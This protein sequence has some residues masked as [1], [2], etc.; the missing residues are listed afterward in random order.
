MK[1]RKQKSI[2]HYRSLNRNRKGIK[3]KF[4]AGILL[5]VFCGSLLC[6]LEFQAVENSKQEMGD[7]NVGHKREDADI[8][9]QARDFGHWDITEKDLVLEYDDRYSL[10]DI[11]EGWEVLS[12]KTGKI[13]S[14]KVVKGENTGITDRDVI[15]QSNGSNGKNIIASGV[16]TAEV[17]LVS[18]EQLEIA[19][20]ILDG[21]QCE[22]IRETIEVIQINV[23]VEPADLTLIYIAG[24]SN[25]EGWCSSSTGYRVEESVVCSEGEVYSTYAPLSVRANQISGVSFSKLCTVNNAADFVAGNLKSDVSVSGKRLEYSLNKLTAEGRGKTGPDSGL[26]YEWNRLT[27]DK[28]WIVNTAQ[29]GTSISKWIPGE[30]CYEQSMAV[31]W[32]VQKTYQA[33][34]EAGHYKAG[35][36]LLF[37]LQGESDKG[38]TAESYYKLFKRVCNVMQEELALDRIG[39][40]MVRSNEGSYTNEEDISMSGPRIAQ[41]VAGNSRE[42]PEV[43]VVS[44]VNEQ[45]VSDSGVRNYFMSTYPQGEL[46]YPTHNGTLAIPISMS[47]IHAD[48]HYSQI[49][50]NENG[51]TAASGMYNSFCQNKNTLP[52]VFG[53]RRT[54]KQIS[55]LVI[56][57]GDKG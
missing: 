8:E 49:A 23:T 52:E 57:V 10:S 16:G 47:E 20:A 24:Q 5:V 22:D 53:D 44:N 18:E 7:S 38:K 50:H 56:D 41:Y 36:Q 17:L 45:W 27:G 25:A 26:A 29:G 46:T 4:L 40:I 21:K 51:I 55:E 13:L 11:K 3:K 54:S 34:V 28:V 31:N 14:N 35:K 43:F 32:Q 2:F 37:W 1:L 9:D 30:I 42:L 15:T 19:R 48:I 12:I 6:F 39:I 33:E